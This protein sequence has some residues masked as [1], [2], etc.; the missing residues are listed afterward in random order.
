MR[1]TVLRS[2]EVFCHSR[3]HFFNPQSLPCSSSTL[4][5]SAPKRHSVWISPR[6]HRP[7]M[8]ASL[9]MNA[10]CCASVLPDYAYRACDTSTTASR[11][12]PAR[13]KMLS[14]ALVVVTWAQ[15]PWELCHNCAISCV[16]RGMQLFVAIA[17]VLSKLTPPSIVAAFY[18]YCTRSV[19]HTHTHSSL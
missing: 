15:W 13:P 18:V 1:I 19:S 11:I 6:R 5:R 12:A 8:C 3:Y 9:S 17:K 4:S 16:A 14:I 10:S 7:A 2:S